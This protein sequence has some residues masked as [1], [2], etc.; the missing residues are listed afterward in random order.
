M[1][2]IA[3]GAVLLAGLV[4]GLTRAAQPASAPSTLPMESGTLATESGTPLAA[5]ADYNADMLK[6]DEKMLLARQHATTE[7]AKRLSIAVARSDAR[8]GKFVATVADRFGES[9]RT[10]VLKAFE[11]LGPEDVTASFV[12]GDLAELKNDK[13]ELLLPLIRVDGRWLF[14]LDVMIARGGG[15]A[16]PMLDSALARE[17]VVKVLTQ[18]MEAGRLK[19]AGEI[20]GRVKEALRE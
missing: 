4:G 1:K 8:V 11:D 5:L 15:K 13:G 20:A 16:R 19:S 6:G 7:D 2:K 14:D 10:E 18:E 3:M 9:A 12:D 17:N